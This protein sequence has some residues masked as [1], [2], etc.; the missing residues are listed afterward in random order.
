VI[1]VTHSRA[2]HFFGAGPV[3]VNPPG[4]KHAILSSEVAREVEVNAR[5]AVMLAWKIMTRTPRCSSPRSRTRPT[6]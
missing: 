5:L 2:Y 1:F 6:S 3:P 4:T